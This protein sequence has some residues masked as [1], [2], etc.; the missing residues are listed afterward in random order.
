MNRTAPFSP[1]ALALA[2]ASC[3]TGAGSAGTPTPAAAGDTWRSTPPPGGPAPQLVAP[4]PERHVLDNGLTVLLVRRP[5]LPLARISVVV[6]AGSALDPASRPGLASFL[7]EMLRA[8]T[9]TRTAAEI[10]DAIETMGSEL[11]ID[12]EE[13]ALSLGA[14]VLDATFAEAL[15]I[16]ADVTLNP[17]FAA[18]E[19]TRV[20]GERLAALAQAE[21]DPSYR[22]MSVLRRVLYPGHGYGHLVLG[23][24]ASL[25]AV[26][27]ADLRAFY[28]AHVRPANA[29][30]I[31]VG[32]VAPEI[33][34]AAVAGRFGGWR[35]TPGSTAPAGD[36]TAVAPAVIAVNKAGA[37][38]S[39]LCIGHVGVPRSHSDYF[40]LV[41]ANSIL[42]GSFNSR[43]NM[44]LREDK[45]Y[46]YGARSAFDFM[47][48]PGPFV[49]TTAVES[50]ATAAA[51]REVIKEIITLREADATREELSNAKSRYSVSLPGYFQAV[52]TIAMMMGN[53]VIFDLPLDYYQR[54]PERIAAVGL[55]DVRRVAVEHLQ[56]GN[57]A[58]VVVGDAP[59][60]VPARAELGRGEVTVW[61]ESPVAPER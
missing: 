56:P 11:E 25:A 2:L 29:T 49:V 7:G 6:R 37:P 5:T 9:T 14:T 60:V 24:A 43:I 57:L 13:D 17:A 23:S 45:G 47:R 26:T 53:I 50:P 20:R 27:D 59:T 22:A 12:V 16:I 51:I 39:E 35:G 42:G 10:S 36:A 21:D 8:G 61:T 1:L 55:A 28:A 46:T 3:A 19:V 52:E 32:S 15:D 44:N 54:L 41:I 40:A 4:V 33:A 48:G 58:V 38:Q 34:L 18:A 30:V 31:V